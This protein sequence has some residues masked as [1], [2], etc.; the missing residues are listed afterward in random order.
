MWD[1]SSG[2]LLRVLKGHSAEVGGLAFSPD[3]KLLLTSSE[4]GMLIIWD[5]ATGEL[6]QD[7]PDFT[8]Y[9][10]S[11]SPDGTRVAAATFNGLQV[12]TYTPDSAE[13]I[14]L[15]ESQAYVT[16]PEGSAGI[17]SPD[18]KWLA[19]LSLSTASGNAIKLWDATT[20]QELLTLVGHTDWVQGLAFSP[21]GKRLASTSFDGTVQNM[22]PPAGKG[23][24]G[25]LWAG[26]RVWESRCLQSE[27]EGIRDKW[28][29]W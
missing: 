29:G 2:D 23:N 20:G 19:A 26:S 16:I 17:F 6:L 11:F 25:S 5:V 12:W 18:G 28:R 13:P 10:V 4:D 15:D 7:I 14:S 9:K 3:G 27:W 8:V 21:D 22:E 1:A 24:S